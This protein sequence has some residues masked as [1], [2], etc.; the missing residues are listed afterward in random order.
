MS[1]AE[2]LT[3]IYDRL[4]QLGLTANY[5]GF[6]HT[7]RAVYLAYKDP[8]RLTCVTKWLYPE[9]A[10]HY[11]TNWRTVE[12]NIRY[13]IRILWQNHPNRICDLTGELLKKRPSPSKLISL[14]VALIK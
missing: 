13:S 10:D 11:H 2:L 9:V 7:A 12:H 5:S 3:Q 1:D 6:F 8:Q 14:V 4:Y